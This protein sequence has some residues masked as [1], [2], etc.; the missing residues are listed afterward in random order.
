MKWLPLAWLLLALPAE[1]EPLVARL[2][3]ERVAIT[4]AFVG[5]SLMIFGATEAP[6]AEAG[7]AGGDQLVMVARGPTGA[8]TVRRRVQVLGLW[9]NGPST[10]FVDVPVFYSVA[11]EWRALPAALRS[12]L[13][14]G[15]EAIPLEGGGARGQGFRAALREL[16]QEARLWQEDAAVVQVSGGR[17]FSLRLDL[18][19]TVQPGSYRVE[20]HLLRQGRLVATEQLGFVVA[21]TGFA[22]EVAEVA[23]G[24]PV[25]YAVLCILLAAMA[26]WA[27]SVFFRRS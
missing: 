10:R 6:L 14:L 8:F 3:T 26:G 20:V 21:R 24:Q 19:S 23:R 4:T 12:E 1:A 2:S 5:E 7:P 17:L 9:L 13:G 27:G 25:L 18:P 16:K 15:L 11:G 22:A